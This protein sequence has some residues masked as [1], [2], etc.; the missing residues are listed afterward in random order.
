MTGPGFG[1]CTV[2]LVLADAVPA[3]KAAVAAEYRRRTGLTGR[4][5]PA[6]LV[7]GAGPVSTI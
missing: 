7:D 1:G 2:N 6:E 3:L 4:V 5:F